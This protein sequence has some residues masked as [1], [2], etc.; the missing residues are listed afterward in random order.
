MNIPEQ[1]RFYKF[2]FFIITDLSGKSY[3]GYVALFEKCIIHT[4]QD[5]DSRY[6][7]VGHY[8]GTDVVLNDDTF[9]ILIHQEIIL[10]TTS[11]VVYDAWKSLLTNGNSAFF[12]MRNPID[13]S[14]SRLTLSNTNSPL[15]NTNR[16]QYN[17]FYLILNLQ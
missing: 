12:E 6:K 4:I 9:S 11:K 15:A 17:Y 3:E 13:K 8:F 14:L 2:D 1:G 16:N 7:Y 10:S 5:F